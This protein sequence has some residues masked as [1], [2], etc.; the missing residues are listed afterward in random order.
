M[1]KKKGKI[2]K[3]TKNLILKIKFFI[4]NFLSY[5]QIKKKS[6]IYI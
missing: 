5:L 1:I 3:L 6:Y 2:V 4:K